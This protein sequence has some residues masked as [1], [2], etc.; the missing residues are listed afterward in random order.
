[1]L[2]KPLRTFTGGIAILVGGKTAV[3]SAF[4]TV[5]SAG[6]CRG[7]QLNGL[8]PGMARRRFTIVVMGMSSR[9]NLLD[10]W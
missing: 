6:K 4:L 9:S 1:L 2:C 5:L 8:L 10:L 7:L 3:F